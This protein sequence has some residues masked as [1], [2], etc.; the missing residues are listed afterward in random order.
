MVKRGVVNTRRKGGD[1]ILS[2]K[3]F[4]RLAAIGVLCGSV[5]AGREVVA[6]R[7]L[8]YGLWTT[9]LWMVSCGSIVGTA[10]GVTG[11]A[12]LLLI[13][14][15]W[16]MA[17]ARSSNGEAAHDLLADQR[18][19]FGRFGVFLG[20]IVGI[21]L[22]VSPPES[23]LPK[24][25]SHAVVIVTVYTGVWIVLGVLAAA[26]SFSNASP[27]RW[28]PIHWF[29]V[30]ALA[31]IVTML[32]IWVSAETPR[33]LSA[34][35]LATLLAA[36]LVYVLLLRPARGLHERIGHPIGSALLGPLGTIFVV[37]I[38]GSATALIAAASMRRIASHS[39]AQ[40]LNRNVILIGI[41]TL[42][43][44]RTN[45]QDDHRERDLCPNLKRL[46]ERGTVFS[47]ARSQ[48]PWTLPSFACMMTGLYPEEHKAEHLTS[49]LSPAQLTLA[50]IL[51][52]EGY[53]TAAVVSC[54]FLN[55]ASGMA[56]GFDMHDESQV[57]GHRAITSAAV[58]DRA[59]DFLGQHSDEPFF[60][61]VHYFDPHFSYQDHAEWDFAD[62]YD[63]WLRDAVHKADQNAFRRFIKALGP[64][65]KD[66]L[67]ASPA[68][69]AFIGDTY[70]EEIAYT[71]SQIGRIIDY[72]EAADLWDST[73]VIA[74][75]D[76]GEE[77]L[78]R[79]WSGHTVTLYEEQIHVPLVVVEPDTESPPSPRV[80]TMPVETRSIFKTVAEFLKVSTPDRQTTAPALLADTPVRSV[81]V[82]SSTR[83]I[84]EQPPYGQFVPKYVWLSALLD[85]HWKLIKDHLHGRVQLFDLS[86][87][88]EEKNEC[89][90]R[91]PDQRQR[92]ERRLDALDAQ[93]DLGGASGP[94]P[95]ASEEQKRRLR[96]LG[97]L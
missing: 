21:S 89:G 53:R 45:L 33:E 51:R 3:M 35:L 79:N 84:K 49:T 10:V 85:G 1:P 36:A 93:L 67:Q 71:D 95:D 13:E 83:P 77:L 34:G 50:E 30:A 22:L 65:F 37:L 47:N 66:Q 82:R 46:A 58:T 12:V 44:D 91:Y 92:L 9:S 8:D 24:V 61:F 19:A 55:A 86:G 80:E 31:T 68:D 16:S 18:S 72:I 28:F 4:I 62:H 97:Y 38:L 48:A 57:L 15:L 7:Y 39:A 43:Y 26:V 59:I 56:Q 63:G 75:S 11:G 27:R 94:P 88:P 41:D 2:M 20:L 69:I 90:R 5:V 70:D 87:D 32:H 54:D 81:T 78:E 23:G 73:L 60:L 17:W 25:P 14:R 76:H 64:R 74:V 6:Q 42:R 52:E 29:G 40:R 96:S